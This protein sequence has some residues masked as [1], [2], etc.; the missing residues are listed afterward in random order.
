MDEHFDDDGRRCF[1][2]TFSGLNESKE[3]RTGKIHMFTDGGYI[4]EEYVHDVIKKDFKLTQ[5]YIVGVLE[6]DSDDFDDFIARKEDYNADNATSQQE[7]S[8]NNEDENDMD[9]YI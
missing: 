2:I 1:V 3:M 5:P 8:N 6:M 9:K 7:P 4:N